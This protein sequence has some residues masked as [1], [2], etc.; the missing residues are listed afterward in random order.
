MRRSMCCSPLHH[1]NGLMSCIK[2]ENNSLICRGPNVALFAINIVPE[3]KHLEFVFLR[4]ELHVLPSGIYF[5]SRDGPFVA[6]QDCSLDIDYLSAVGMPYQSRVLLRT[7]Q[8]ISHYTL[9]TEML[10]AKR[11]LHAGASQII[12]T[13]NRS[14]T[15][16]H[17]GMVNLSNSLNASVWLG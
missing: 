8:L 15:S 7:A 5:I 12:Q 11:W 9:T 13:K 10:R 16:I 3:W 1:H 2:I 4:S 6:S 14:V 17:H